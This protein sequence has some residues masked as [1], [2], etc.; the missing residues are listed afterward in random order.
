MIALLFK[1]RITVE[2]GGYPNWQSCMWQIVKCHKENSP[3]E[4]QSSERR[5][6]GL[7]AV[8]PGVQNTIIHMPIQP[9]PLKK[10]ATRLWVT[11]AAETEFFSFFF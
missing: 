11:D 2:R 1:F 7:A 9:A 4:L 8:S 3:R 10:L 6:K 5:D